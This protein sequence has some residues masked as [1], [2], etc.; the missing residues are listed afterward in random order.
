MTFPLSK[1]QES[2][3]IRMGNYRVIYAIRDDRLFVIVLRT[4]HRKDFYCGGS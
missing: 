3:R 1:L 2:Y 4:G